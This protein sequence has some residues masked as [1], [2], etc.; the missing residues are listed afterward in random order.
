MFLT[1]RDRWTQGLYPVPA[2]SFINS[3]EPTAELRPPKEGQTD[4][5][6]LM[7]YELLDAIER[8]A[9]RDKKTPLEELR[10]YDGVYSV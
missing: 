4:E 2:L 10:A 7:P 3:Q 9:I 6:D 8:S 5:K 1:C